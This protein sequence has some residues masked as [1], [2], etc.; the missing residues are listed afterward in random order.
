MNRLIWVVSWF[1]CLW[2]ERWAYAFSRWL[3]F[4]WWHLLRYR[5]RVMLDNLACA[6]PDLDGAA[7]RRLGRQACQ[8]LVLTF[9]EVFRLP[10]YHRVGLAEMVRT[11]GMQNLVAADAKGKGVLILSG[12]LGS[13]EVAVAGVAQGGWPA[14]LVVKNFGPAMDHF[15]TTV[16]ERSQLA[17]IRARGAVRPIMKALKNKETV[18]FV[19]DQNATRSI[20]VFVDFFGKPACT[21][22]A[23]AVLA[24]RT[25]AAVV[26]AVPI[27]T[28]PGQ[29]LM[30]VLPE[31]PWQEQGD[32]EASVQHMTQVYT[33]V[34]EQAIIANPEQ[35]FW[36]HKRWRTRPAPA[37]NPP[38][39]TPKSE[40][41]DA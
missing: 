18:V 1:L 3:G 5:R 4:I 14:S 30:R 22:S 25:G 32:R 33:Q 39:S 11:E 13:W 34:I 6:F 27:R 31:I 20:G 36:T 12:H 28:G 41:A 37:P 29:H 7:R 9:W 40:A 19:L 17:V 24:Q 35:W 38:V 16:R 26:P 10:R 8:H 21:M 2:P 15:M 23:L